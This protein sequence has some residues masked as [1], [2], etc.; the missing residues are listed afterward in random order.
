MHFHLKYAYGI[1]D[2]NKKG[3]K[4]CPYNCRWK[5][6][7]QTEQLLNEKLKNEPKYIH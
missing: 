2:K 4:K 6:N 5:W 1:Y 7:T 3:K